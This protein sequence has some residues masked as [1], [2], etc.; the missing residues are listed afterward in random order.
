MQLQVKEQIKT[1]LAQKGKK[2]KDLVLKMS[3]LMNS[4][5]S[6]NS[7]SHKMKRGTI[8]YTE[9]LVIAEILGYEVHF[10]NTNNEL[11]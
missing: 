1:L 7:F 10:V 4:K 9:M 3:E 2:Q 6:S 8:T 5:Y 11:I